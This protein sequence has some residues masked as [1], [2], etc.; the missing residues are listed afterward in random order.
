M[1]AGRPYRKSAK[2]VG[3]VMGNYHPHGDSA[4]YDALARMTQDWSMRR[5]VDRRSGQ[6]RLDG[7]RSAGVDA[8]YRSAAEKGRQRAARRSRQGYRRFPAQL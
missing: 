5:A 2:I 4:I 3:D 7:P 8:L 1:V 6:F